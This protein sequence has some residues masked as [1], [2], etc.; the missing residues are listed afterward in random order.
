MDRPVLPRRPQPPVPPNF[1]FQDTTDCRNHFAPRPRQCRRR[2]KPLRRMPANCS[3]RHHWTPSRAIRRDWPKSC[4]RYYLQPAVYNRPTD[5]PTDCT[6]RSHSDSRLSRAPSKR[7]ACWQ[8][9]CRTAIERSPSRAF[10]PPTAGPVYRVNRGA[11]GD[12]WQVCRP[13]FCPTNP[14]R[15][16]IRKEPRRSKRPERNELLRWV[17]RR[18][19]LG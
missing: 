5:S 17:S 4:R 6:P 15:P 8:Q 9:P 12:G 18:H 13:S 1:H 3:A 19:P 16:S 11:R 7:S 14:I 2:S 10:G